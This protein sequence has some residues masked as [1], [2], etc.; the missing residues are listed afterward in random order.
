MIERIE[1]LKAELRIHA[2]GEVEVFQEGR[3][4]LVDSVGPDIPEGQG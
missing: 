2:L 4:Q 1:H 3:I